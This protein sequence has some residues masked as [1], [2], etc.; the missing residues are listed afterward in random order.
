MGCNNYGECI[1][2]LKDHYISL[3]VFFEPLADI[4]GIMSD[5]VHE[6]SWKEMNAKDLNICL[7]SI[8]DLLYELYVQPEILKERRDKISQMRA[9][10]VNKNKGE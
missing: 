1:K 4:T 3:D 9:K 10:A 8:K 2:E 5:Q 7:E 6:N